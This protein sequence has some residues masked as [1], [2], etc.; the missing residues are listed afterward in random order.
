MISPAQEALRRQYG[1]GIADGMEMTLRL[2]LGQ[3]V[4]GGSPYAGPLPGEFVVWAE[5]ALERVEEA[6]REAGR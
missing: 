4:E 6:K 5:A 2:S 3:E 1:Q